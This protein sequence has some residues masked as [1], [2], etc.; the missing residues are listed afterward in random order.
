MDSE[1]IQEIATAFECCLFIHKFSLCNINLTPFKYNLDTLNMQY[2]AVQLW[3]LYI[4]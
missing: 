2:N 4:Y 3:K 1:N